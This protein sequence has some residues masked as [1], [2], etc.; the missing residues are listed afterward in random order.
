MPDKVKGARTS[1]Q[2]F[3]SK[4]IRQLADMQGNHQNY[5]KTAAERWMQMNNEERV[6]YQEIATR[7][8]Q[9]FNEETIAYEKKLN[10]L[11]T[12]GYF[13][14]DA[15]GK[16]TDEFPPP[17]REHK[18]AK[19]MK[20]YQYYHNGYKA[21]RKGHELWKESTAKWNAMSTVE[22]A[23]YRA[24]NVKDRARFHKQT[25]ELATKGFFTL[26]DGKRSCD[27]PPKKIP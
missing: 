8:I 26:E 16:S 12:K 10:E 6:P 27:L 17:S 4:Y 25:E 18:P 3:S 23:P 2:F 14:L 7:D 22:Q 5:F 21:R 20:A 9:R 13:T 15:G 24:L 1:Q 11:K 19:P